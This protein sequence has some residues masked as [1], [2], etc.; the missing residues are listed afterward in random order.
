MT[1]FDGIAIAILLLSL[2]LGVWRGLAYEVLSLAGWPLAWLAS[3]WFAADI[4]PLLPVQQE[5]MRAALAYALLF[6]VTLLVWGVLVWLLSK[7]IKAAGLG[8]LDRTLGGVFGIVRGVLVILVLVWLAGLTHIPE[9]P[10]WRDAQSS[11][12]AE[13]F[14][15]LTKGCLPDN[16]AQRIRFGTRS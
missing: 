5:V 10:Y 7:L 13:R 11:R 8:A 1:L 16:V 14:A 15:M 3:K 2:L 12:F 6:V 4:A 9:Q